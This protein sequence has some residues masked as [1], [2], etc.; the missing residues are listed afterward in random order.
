M[1][2]DPGHAIQHPA[3]HRKAVKGVVIAFAILAGP[4]AWALQ[5]LANYGF[6]SLVCFP[7]REP[8]MDLPPRWN[9]LPLGLLI[10]TL[11]ALA[12]SVVAGVL[13]YRGW[14]RTQAEAGGGYRHL[15]EV[16][17]GRTRFLASWGLWIGALF[18]VALLFDVVGILLVT[19]CGD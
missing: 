2:H 17:E 10:A 5:L 7:A 13:G 16:G 11:V 3:P 4:T 15:I 18:S 14:R 19:S 8:H 1:T 12:V 9:G 6:A